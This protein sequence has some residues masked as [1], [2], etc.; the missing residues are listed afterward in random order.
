MA[1]SAPYREDLIKDF[2][3]ICGGPD[4]VAVDTICEAL[5][6]W[7]YPGT[8]VPSTVL[9]AAEGLGTNKMEE[10]ELVGSA[11]RAG[12]AA[13]QAAEHGSAGP[14]SQRESDH[15]IDLR[16]RMPRHRAHPVGSAAGRRHAGQTEAASLCLYRP[17]VRGEDHSRWTAT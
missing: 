16:S 11:D 17:A 12:E 1:R 5:M 4:P 10:I 8:N 3:T 14:I 15:G 2:N 13:V 7:D 9:G 6:D